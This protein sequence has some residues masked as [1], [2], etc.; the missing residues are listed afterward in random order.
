MLP[1]DE[2][3]LLAVSQFRRAIDAAGGE[4]WDNKHITFPHGACGHASELLGQYLIKQFGIVAEYVNQVAPSDIGGWHGSHAWLEWNGLTLD[5]TGD[6]F[7]WP[8]VI[9]TRQPQFHGQGESE[10]R[11]P[12]CLPHQRD[13]WLRECGALWAA[14]VP[15][16]DVSQ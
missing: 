4:P 3:V 10:L 14:I 11:H 6:Q 16:V 5:I 7:G 1:T 9:V 13:W 2:E 12:V 15:F 8:P